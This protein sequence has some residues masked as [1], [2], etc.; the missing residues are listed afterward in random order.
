MAP[1]HKT[2]HDANRG[3]QTFVRGSL[4]VRL[5]N[6]CDL[7]DNKAKPDY[8]DAGAKPGQECAV[9]GKLV[10]AHAPLVV[11]SLEDCTT[12]ARSP[13]AADLPGRILPVQVRPPLATLAWALD[14]PLWGMTNL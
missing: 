1:P 2:D 9:I 14:H 8:G 6:Q 4:V 3:I 10:V 12:K 11:G 7:R 13:H 5:H